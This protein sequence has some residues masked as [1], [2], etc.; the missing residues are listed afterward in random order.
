[1]NKSLGRTLTATSAVTLILLSIDSL[2]GE[3]QEQEIESKQQ[4]SPAELYPVATEEIV[5][6][7]NAF[8]QENGLEP[9][10]VDPDLTN[11]AAQFAK[12][13][14]VN[15]KYGHTADGRR[16][17][18]R[19]ESAG[20][21]YCVVRENIAYRLDTAGPEPLALGEF[22]VEGWK[23]SEEHRKNMLAAHITETGVA[24]A[25]DDGETF[26]AVQMFGRPESAKY[27]IKI[28]NKMDVGQ[29]VVFRAEGNRD[30]ITVPPRVVLTMSRC[31]PSTVELAEKSEQEG[32]ASEKITVNSKT[33]FEIVGDKSSG[34][35]V[36]ARVEP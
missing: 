22:F 21:D 1:M 25:S 17:S 8:R 10:T 5:E 34:G 35:A 20:Y 14:A 28:T 15:D 31:L 19:A 9:V 23:D 7:T 12:F 27:Q 18:E 30:E 24:V 3:V 32:E 16:P 4:E 33:N 13:M 26:F 6:A 2:R 36:L 11:A 29:T